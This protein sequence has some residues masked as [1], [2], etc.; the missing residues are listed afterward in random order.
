MASVPELPPLALPALGEKKK[1]LTLLGQEAA[2]ELA[3]VPP[4]KK[5]VLAFAIVGV[6][7]VAGVGVWFGRNTIV[8][9]LAQKDQRPAVVET[10]E[11]KAMALYATGQ[12]AYN[13][14]QLDEAVKS[15]EGAL[16]LMPKYAKAHRALAI[17]LAKQNKAADAVEHYKAYLELDPKAT[18]AA[19]VR[20]IVEDY[21][22]AK[23]AGTV[24]PPPDKKDEES[25][26]PA[27]KGKHRKK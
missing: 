27:P 10:A 19:Q 5:P 3:H 11:D 24:K 16:G 17:A 14:T 18:D 9:M 1:E 15:F 23:A 6:L 12:E 8:G 25:A 4:R 20:K 2:A 21:E 26:A 7:L 22:K 13:K